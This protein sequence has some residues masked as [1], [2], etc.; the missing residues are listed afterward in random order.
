MI[1]SVVFVFSDQKYEN[2]AME[3]ATVVY[4][5]SERHLKSTF[6]FTETVNNFRLK[7]ERVCQTVRFIPTFL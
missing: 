4:T 3:L 7:Q 1:K 5:I 2:P 6:D